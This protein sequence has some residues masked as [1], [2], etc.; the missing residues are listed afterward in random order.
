MQFW[1][2]PKVLSTPEKT[3]IDD[4]LCAGEFSGT[5]FTKSFDKAIYLCYNEEK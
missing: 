1:M 3:Y 4:S 5:F 2:Q